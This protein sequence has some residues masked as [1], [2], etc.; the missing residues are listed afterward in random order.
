MSPKCPAIKQLK[1][2][3]S[4]TSHR[5]S[6]KGSA[7]SLLVPLGENTSVTVILNKLDVFMVMCL[8]VKHLSN[9]FIVIFKKKR[10]LLLSMTLG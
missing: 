8:L 5:N 6:L 10:N 1:G 4:I 7:R 2:T 9:H 3:Y